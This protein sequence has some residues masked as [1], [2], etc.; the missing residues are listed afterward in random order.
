MK[1]EKK[2]RIESLSTEEMLYEINLGRKSRFQRESFA[3]LQTIYEK[4]MNN[5]FN[6]NVNYQTQYNMEYVKPSEIKHTTSNKPENKTQKEAY[7][8]EILPTKRISLIKIAERVIALL[9]FA[10]LGWICWYYFGIHF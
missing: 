4:R 10:F 5:N 8:V 3:H 6:H 1:D 7:S 9:L 2:K